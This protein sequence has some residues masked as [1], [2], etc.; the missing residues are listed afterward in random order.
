MENDSQLVADIMTKQV[1]TIDINDELSQAKEIMDEKGIRHLPVMENGQLSGILSM[2]DINQLQYM[3][4][5][6]QGKVDA[7]SFFLIFDIDQLMTKNVM[8]VES[9]SSISEASKIFIEKNF[10]AMPVVEGGELVGILSV[11]DVLKY[12]IS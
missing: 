10:H 8:V 12:Y 6:A 7:K 5:F 11:K 9:D 1:V 2:T 4:E 3:S